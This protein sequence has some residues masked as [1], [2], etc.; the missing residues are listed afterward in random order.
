MCARNRLT[1]I[2]LMI[3]LKVGYNSSITITYELYQAIN[4]SRVYRTATSTVATVLFK[5]KVGTIHHHYL[6]VVSSYQSHPGTITKQR[7]DCWIVGETQT[8]DII[9][10][11][12]GGYL[13]L[14]SLL[15]Q[16]SWNQH[17]SFLCFIGYYWYDPCP[18]LLWWFNCQNYCYYHPSWCHRQ[19]KIF[20][21][22]LSNLLVESLYGTLE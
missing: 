17:N 10:D 19:I 21:V 16:P 20:I 6:R 11:D 15:N 4:R 1:L 18:C 2:L 14:L 7:T 3:E 8:N 5:L 22:F 9:H 12:W 13:F